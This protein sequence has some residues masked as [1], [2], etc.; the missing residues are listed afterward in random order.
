MSPA[1]SAQANA[2]T[3]KRPKTAWGLYLDEYKKTRSSVG[4]I[5]EFNELQ[6]AASLL[7]K[8][9]TPEEKEVCGPH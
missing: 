7:W 5:G 2:S 3:M 9:M 1:G 6:K 8:S 4:G